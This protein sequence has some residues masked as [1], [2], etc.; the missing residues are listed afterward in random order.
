[1]AFNANL[2]RGGVGV[3]LWDFDGQFVA[4]FAAP[5]AWVNFV[6]HVEAIVVLF[7]MQFALNHGFQPNTL[8]SDS[9]ILVKAY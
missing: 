1:M 2:L 8:E 6:E 7:A 5:V 9:L 4:G 3:V